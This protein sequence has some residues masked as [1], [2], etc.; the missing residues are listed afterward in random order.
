MNP[1]SKQEPFGLTILGGATERR[2]N[3]LRDKVDFP[4]GS[5]AEAE[6]PDDL[7][8]EARDVWTRI[9]FIEYRSAA[10]MNAVAET[11]IAARAPLDLTALASSFA[12]DELSHAEMAARVLAE[13]GGGRT[14]VHRARDLITDK[15]SMKLEPMLRAAEIIVR[16]FCVCES[17]ALPMAQLT[18]KQSSKLPLISAVLNRIAKDEAAH[19]SFGWTFFDWAEAWLTDEHR[20]YLARSAQEMVDVYRQ[21]VHDRSDDH[22]ATFGW[23]SDRD[24]KSHGDRVIKNDVIR[25]LRM[26][27]MYVN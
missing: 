7:R 21:L 27:G 10:G 24:F 6:L 18:A 5:L 22:S 20:A 23:L 26:R 9:A 4:W 25:P 2:F 15:P 1:S 19:A 8:A 13:L 16:I 14:L 11:M 17:F 12:F 3:G